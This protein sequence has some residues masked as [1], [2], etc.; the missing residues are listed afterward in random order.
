MIDI[1]AW[2]TSNGLRATVALAETELEHRVHPIDLGAKAN[3]SPDYL[4]INPSGQTPTLVDS[5]S[6]GGKRLVLRQSGAIVLYACR[7]ANRFIPQDPVDYA[8]ALQWFMQAASDIAGTSA[9]L[10][11]VEN[12]SPEK[13]PAHI[14]RFKDRF[15]RYFNDVEKQLS[16]RAYLAGEVSFADFMLY[17][18]YALKKDLLAP[19]AFPAVTA[20]GQRMSLRPGVQAGMTPFTEAKG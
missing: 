18:N 13:V 19:E 17:P 3:R 12:V 14:K 4:S 20:W 11:Q 6:D 9:A 15:I 2:R 10:N 5:D 16:D 8:V 1:Y 7:K